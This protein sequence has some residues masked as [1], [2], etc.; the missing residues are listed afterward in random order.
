MSLLKKRRKGV[1]GAPEKKKEKQK[2]QKGTIDL[3]GYELM[4]LNGGG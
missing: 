3:C 2:R 1:E 4:L